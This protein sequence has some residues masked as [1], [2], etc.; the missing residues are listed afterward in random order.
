LFTGN[1]QAQEAIVAS[2]GD[3]SGSEGSVNYSFGQVIYIFNIGENGIE[4]QGVQ[5]PY[6]ISVSKQIESTNFLK[7]HKT[8][9]LDSSFRVATVIDDGKYIN[10]KCIVYPNPTIN[11]LTLAIDFFN[12]EKGDFSY[13]LF[14]INGKLLL[15]SKVENSYTRIAMSNLISGTYYL[16]IKQGNKE[17]KTFKIVKSQ[18]N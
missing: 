9:N 3:I 5:Q 14:D 13:R 7:P 16:N 11:I 8:S 10:L 17:I 4:A 15:S 12:I 2:G 6:M 18:N 1:L